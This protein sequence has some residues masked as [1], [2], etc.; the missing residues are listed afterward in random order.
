MMQ[1]KWE[2]PEKH[3]YNCLL[4]YVDLACLTCH[5]PK[6]GENDSNR[7]HVIRNSTIV[8]TD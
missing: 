8:H 5:G 4:G 3:T 2:E 7:K 6:G 1:N